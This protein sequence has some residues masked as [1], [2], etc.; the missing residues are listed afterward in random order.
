MSPQISS[1]YGEHRLTSRWDL[2]ASL[3]HPCKFQRVSRLGS[4]T[5]WHSSS[6]CQPNF[7][8]LNRGRH[9]YS[10]G[11]PSRWALAYIFLYRYYLQRL[12]HRH[13]RDRY[14]AQS[15]M[16]ISTLAT[17]GWTVIFRA[18][19]RNPGGWTPRP[20]FLRCTKY[21]NVPKTCHLWLGVGLTSTY[22]NRFWQFLAKMLVRKSGI[23]RHFIFPRHPTNAS[24][25]PRKRKTRK[26]YIFA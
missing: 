8:A 5:A 17:D 4:V 18:A 3:G 7:V 26:F 22:I 12:Y 24:A 1:Q 16:T 2:L 19:N 25:L 14:R 11:R 15:N 23:K 20:S 21:Y 13:R 10:A 6:G 9:L